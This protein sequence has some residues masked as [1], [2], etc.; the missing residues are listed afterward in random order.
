VDIRVLTYSRNEIKMLPL[1]KKWCDHHGLT[2]AYFDNESTDGSREWAIENNVFESDIITDGKFDIAYTMSV[3]EN[4]RLT[5]NYDY[6]IV[7]GV[8][9]FISGFKG[10]RLADYISK[11]DKEGF[12]S[13]M[14]QYVMLCRNDDVSTLDFCYYKRGIL[15]NEKM[16]LI[17]RHDKKLQVDNIL[18]VNPKK[19]MDLWWFNCGNTKT[20]KERK[21]TYLRRKKAWDNGLNKGYGRH[22]QDLANYNFTLPNL[23]TKNLKELGTELQLKEL[24]RLLDRLKI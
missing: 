12:D 11:I 18:G 14:C 6:S 10:Q 3:L 5:H 21:E 22:Y 2:M 24:C 8:D 16:K 19:D 9:M 1:K 15:H 20:V 13:I 4:Y 7:A 17:A 23:V